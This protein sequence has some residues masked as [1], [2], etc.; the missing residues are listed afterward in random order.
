[1]TRRISNSEKYTM[2]LKCCEVCCE[3]SNEESIISSSD[4]DGDYSDE[5]LSVGGLKNIFEK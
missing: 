4:S 1:M 2:I 5:F 3:D